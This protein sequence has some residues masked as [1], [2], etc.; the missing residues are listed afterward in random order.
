MMRLGRRR[1]G[2]M[3]RQAR[4]AADI[5]GT[6]TD[7][8]LDAPAGPFH[9]Q[10]ADRIERAGTRRCRGRQ[11][12]FAR[13]RYCAAERGYLRSWNDAGDQCLDRAQGSEDGILET[14]FEQYDIFMDKPPPLAPRPL[15]L[16]VGESVS[17]CG[18]VLALLDCV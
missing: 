15:R 5:G 17:A 1:N 12:G 11:T 16:P 2:T 4:L 13:K 14:G 7:V 10:D 18:R 6:F 9:D 8:V 3:D